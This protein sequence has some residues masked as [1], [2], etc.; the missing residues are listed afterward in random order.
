MVISPGKLE[1][2]SDFLSKHSN[3]GVYDP[4]KGLCGLLSILTP[5]T[6]SVVLAGMQSGTIYY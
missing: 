3:E 6:K 2:Y 4:K 1:K 5:D